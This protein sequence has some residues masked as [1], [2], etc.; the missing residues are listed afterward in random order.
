LSN[1][2][3]QGLRALD[4]LQLA[5]ALELSKN[6]RIDSIVNVEGLTSINPEA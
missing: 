5:S 2:R 3:A 6:D 4:S 1:H